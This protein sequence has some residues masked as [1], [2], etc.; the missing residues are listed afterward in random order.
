[1]NVN[2]FAI[3]VCAML[4]IVGPLFLTESSLNVI[5]AE[6]NEQRDKQ[7]IIDKTDSKKPKQEK[8][9]KK[10]DKNNKQPDS[11]NKDVKKDT[12]KKT[13]ENKQDSKKEQSGD[14]K[15]PTKDT[16][17]P[18]MTIPSSVKNIV[19]ENTYPNPTQH[20]PQLQP[21]ELTTELINSSKV[22]IENPDLIKML[23]E[24][25]VNSTPFAL[26][27]RAQIFLGKWPLNYESTETAPNWEYQ[28][29]NTNHQDNRGNSTPF[30]ISYNQEVQKVVRG[31]LTA[32]V[33][34]SENVRKMMQLKA[35]ENSGLP[36]AFETVVGGGTKLEQF[37]NIPAQRLGYLN[38]YAPAVNEKGK[39]TYGEV[40]IVLR[41]SKKMIVVKN[42][43]TQGIGA[44]I[45]VQDHLSFSFLAT[46]R[47]K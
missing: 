4:L 33:P 43:T 39:V 3:V 11:K 5:A 47:P 44:W 12:D 42:V 19:K 21:S 1:M 24:S 30:Q 23:N 14:E 41:G 32:K 18:E 13:K 22:K 9:L 15:E 20:I 2:R 36:L 40:Y 29:I 31:G 25:A 10:Q 35:M 7:E 17:K 28:K 6:Q 37:Y 26:G 34:K 46:E 16:K 27:Y 8:E 38:A 45:P